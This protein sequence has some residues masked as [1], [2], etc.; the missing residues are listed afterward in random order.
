MGAVVGAVKKGVGAVGNILG[1]GGKQTASESQTGS[2]QTTFDPIS[3]REKQ[4][5]DAVFD[6]LGR[7]GT[8]LNREQGAAGSDAMKVNQLFRNLLVNTMQSNGFASPE[9]IAQ[10]TAFV[11]ETFTKPAQMQLERFGDSFTQQQAARAAALGRQPDDLGFQREL[12]SELA[13]REA[14]IAAQRGGLV[15]QRADELAFQR[16]A[17]QAQLGLSGAQFFNQNAQRLFQNQVNLANMFTQQ[18]GLGQQMRQAGGRTQQTGNV[19]QIA[20]SRAAPGE[21]VNTAFN[22]GKELLGNLF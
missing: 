10:A 4:A 17:Q 13:Q 11:D 7:Q 12:A 22:A 15:Q 18:Q 1:A 9:Q 8:I 2:S 19:Q 16:P 14:D 6:L 3:G 21:L 20:G 5:Q